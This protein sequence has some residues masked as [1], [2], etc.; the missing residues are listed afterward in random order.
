MCNWQ[1]KEQVQRPCGRICSACWRDKDSVRHGGRAK[2]R[3]FPAS[4]PWSLHTTCPPPF[5]HSSLALQ[6]DQ[7]GGR[8]SEGGVQKGTSKMRKAVQLSAPYP[9]FLSL[10]REGFSF[11]LNLSF[12]GI[13]LRPVSR[14][15]GLWT[16]EGGLIQPCGSCVHLSPRFSQLS[17][18]VLSKPEWWRGTGFQRRQLRSEKVVQL[19]EQLDHLLLLTP[20][21]PVPLEFN[22]NSV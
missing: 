14:R 8:H 22:L 21:S 5:P 17:L 11:M 13:V 2:I 7:E 20:G 10:L 18:V 4:E 9:C 19:T 3:R 15:L 12:A 6:P 1:G 16:V